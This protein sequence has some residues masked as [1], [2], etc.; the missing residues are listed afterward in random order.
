MS[1]GYSWEGIRQVRATLLCA[2]HVPECLWGL[3]LGVLYQVLYLFLLITTVLCIVHIDRWW[4]SL[5]LVL[6]PLPYTWPCKHLSACWTSYRLDCG[7]K[8]TKNCEVVIL[9]RGP[10]AYRSYLS[11]LLCFHSS[12]TLVV[13]WLSCIGIWSEIFPVFFSTMFHPCFYSPH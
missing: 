2:R 6:S 3:L 10:Q 4:H 12:M 1:T 7:L 5:A 13:I 9:L 11:S 8:V